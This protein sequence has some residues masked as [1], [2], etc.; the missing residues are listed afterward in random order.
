MATLQPLKSLQEDLVSISLENYVLSLNQ[1]THIT[2]YLKRPILVLVSL[3]I[4]SLS[5]SVYAESVYDINIPSGSA[6]I[7]APFHWSSEKDGDTSGFIEII[8]ND[9][10]FWRNGDTSAHTVTSGTPQSGPDGI[11]DSGKIHQGKFFVQKFTEIGE[12]PYYCTLHPWRTGLVS[13]VSGYSI[14]PNVG[15]GFGDGTNVFD[16]EYKF[17]RL[18]NR[19]DIDENTKSISFELKGNTINDDNSLTILLPPALISGI[20]SVSVDGIK[21]KEFS[22]KFEEDITILV[23]DEIHPYAKSVIITG[24]TIIPEFGMIAVMMLASAIVL[25]IAFSA[26][27]RLSIKSRY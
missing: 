26:N 16:I 25:I 18:I 11:F 21:T 3:T 23:I 12:F 15:L 13:V 20:S 10:I 5:S 22:Q 9:T 19:A 7:A 6:D 17:N 27:S 4:F 24:T 8:V 1:E 14:L 2:L